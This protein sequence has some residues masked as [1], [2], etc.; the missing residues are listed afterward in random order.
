MSKAPADLSPFVERVARYVRN[1]DSGTSYERK[2]LLSAVERGAIALTGPWGDVVLRASPWDTDVLGVPTG[3][4]EAFRPEGDPPDPRGW[5]DEL[6]LQHLS[7]RLPF[8]DVAGMRALEQ[9]GFRVADV[10]LSLVHQGHT[11]T[12]RDVAVTIRSA[13]EDD[14][15][16][17]SQLA[18]G[19]F[20]VTRF[21]LDP[22]IGSG[23]AD[24][25][26]ARWATD[27]L[28]RSADDV[29]VADLDGTAVGFVVCK[30]DALAPKVLGHEIG[31]I[32]LIAVGGEARGKGVGR[33]LV[34]AAL[35]H[36]L[37]H[38]PRVEVM[39]SA[40]NSSALRLYQR[41]GFSLERGI[42]LTDGVTLHW[43]ERQ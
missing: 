4:I 31:E 25:L 7:L 40:S 38:A 6:D 17:L 16:V 33:A 10:S 22:K 27:A 11:P 34:D 28:A 26:Y 12:E 1:D 19:A 42:A 43:W 15:D 13:T 37:N 36:M 14:R 30:L 39:T 24:A 9:V 29:L 20:A 32:D 41:A 21:H 5:A 3:R 35:A 23:R 2:R 8:V 18:A